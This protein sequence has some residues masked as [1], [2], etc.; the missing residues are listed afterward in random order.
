MPANEMVCG[1]L[2][3]A[4]AGQ[5]YGMPKVLAHNGAWL[6]RALSALLDGGCAHVFLVVGAADVSRATLIRALGPK[7][8]GEEF[9]VSVVHNQEWADGM[10]SSLRV[11]LAAATQTSAQL[12]VIHLVDIPDVGPEVVRRV[13]S[14][15]QGHVRRNNSEASAD[16]ESLHE[17]LHSA[18]AR[19]HFDTVPGHPVAIGR[20]FW[21]ELIARS[22]GDAG[23]REFLRGH[24]DAVTVDCSDLATGR[25]YDEPELP[26]T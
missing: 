21:S 1:I 24:P 17:P 26:A 15:A 7:K 8:S 9:P 19:A 18:L 25:D 6:A 22:E 20:R 10:G 12:A 3:A 11:G 5:R 14:A 4:G 23:A 2:L 13:I 16:D